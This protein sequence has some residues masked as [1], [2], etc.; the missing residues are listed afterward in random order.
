MHLNMEMFFYK[1]NTTSIHSFEISKSYYIIALNYG[2]TTYKVSI[3]L[4]FQK[5]V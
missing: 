3:K 4:D 1:Y 2:M 5:R